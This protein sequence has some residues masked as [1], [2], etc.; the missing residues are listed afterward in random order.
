MPLSFR[1]ITPSDIATLHRWRNL[2][3]VSRWWTPQN[4]SLALARAEYTAYMQPS[5]GVD[6]Y[7]IVQKGRDIGYMQKWAVGRFPDYKPHLPLDDREVGID[8]F[9]GEPDLLHQGIGTQ[10]IQQ[11]LH[12]HVFSD[13]VVPACIIDPLPENAAAIRAYEKAGFAH[14]KTFHHEGKGVY[15][16]R[17]KRAAFE[18]KRH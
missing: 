5:Y 2:P 17:L 1:P 3:H 7:I 15:L 6:A 13:P 11:F 4:P 18:N 16:M 9:I 10:A 12:D 14:E 8:V